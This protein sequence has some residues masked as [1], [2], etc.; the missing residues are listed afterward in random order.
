MADPPIDPLAAILKQ[1]ALTQ[2]QRADI[3][4]AFQASTTT[5]DLTERL[6]PLGVPARVKA[7]LWDLKAR[8]ETH[9]PDFTITNEPPSPSMWQQAA[10][11]TGHAAA[12]AVR[13]AVSTVQTLAKP[14]RWA[15]GMPPAT[16]PPAETTTAGTIGR[17]AEQIAEM[18]I[19][20]SKISAARTLAAQK[21][22]PYLAPAVGRT[23]ARL[24]PQVAVEAAGQ[25]GIAAVQGGDPR[26]AAAGGA[27]I[28]VLGAG[29]SRIT[30]TLP[31]SLK[32]QA[33]KKV[34]QALGPT[35][36]RFKAIAER[37]A[38][39][40]LQRGLGGS[41]EAL[42]EQAA[43]KL[44]QVGSELDAVLTQHATQPI[45]SQPVVDALETAKD[46]FRTTSVAGTVVEFEPRAIKQLTG[47]QQVLT[48]LGPNPTV[49]QLVAVRRA[50]DKVVSQAGGFEHRASGAIG[51]PLKDISEAWAKRE[52]TG[53]IRELLAV[54]VP[55][56]AAINKEWAFW[57]GL[58][59]V[60]T[61]TLKRT[62]PHGVSMG[63][64]LAGGMGTMA[65]A[66][67]GAPMG[68]EAA[69]AGGALGLLAAQARAVV[70]SPRWRLLDAR[71]RNQLADAIVSNNV[72][73]VTLALARISAVQ[74]SK[75]GG[76]TR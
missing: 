71:I 52:A 53:A 54:D 27:A 47:L 57:K 9:P 66:M 60:L 10:E 76:G 55:D 41:R 22:A 50:W 63:Q 62:Q 49:E 75:V 17:G 74:G 18:F 20:A 21:L 69:A 51:V 13:G 5:D 61:Q 30:H 44:S 34:V 26:V 2:T 16:P 64:M 65:G 70:T 36:E 3:W 40:I 12:G 68:T 31:A 24:L 67:A 42:Q 15:T 1:A 19:P 35:K 39:N 48:D 14:I 25:A 6:K 37:L 45:G 7:D 43:S 4:D 33:A 58:N 32:E 46:A 28:P 11:A 72:G 8:E 73:H 23:A 29:L 56:L 59:D 38:P